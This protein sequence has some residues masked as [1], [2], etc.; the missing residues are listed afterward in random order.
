MANALLLEAMDENG[1]VFE[2]QGHQGLVDNVA[3]AGED[4][5]RVGK[6]SS[7]KTLSCSIA[8]GATVMG[9]TATFKQHQG[10]NRL[11]V[12][13]KFLRRAL[14]ITAS[15][16]SLAPFEVRI[17]TPTSLG[18]PDSDAL[19]CKASSSRVRCVAA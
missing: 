5:R 12:D 13:S 19:H 4:C 15:L 1:F 2:V 8:H 9:C 7:Y 6:A 14:D 3:S 11:L 18:A 16:K 17:I 10:G